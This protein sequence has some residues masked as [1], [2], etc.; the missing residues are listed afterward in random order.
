MILHGKNVSS[1]FELNPETLQKHQ[2][3]TTK[4]HKNTQKHNRY[5][6]GDNKL[7]TYELRHELQQL[8]TWQVTRIK[9]YLIQRPITISV[10][11]PWHCLLESRRG[12]A[13][14][15]KGIV[16][17]LGGEGPLFFTTLGAMRLGLAR[18]RVVPGMCYVECSG[19]R[20]TLWD[21]R[22]A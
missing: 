22:Q 12:A 17:T 14:K 6:K 4:T 5:G 8:P 7:T 10:A 15:S 19:T 21:T 13:R 1:V 11:V 16:S 18:S 3:H 20:S 2:K 9:I